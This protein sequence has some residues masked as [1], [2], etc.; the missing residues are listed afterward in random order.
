MG[1]N[2]T[3]PVN[4]QTANLPVVVWLYGEAFIFGSKDAGFSDQL[5]LYN[6]SG[7]LSQG[8]DFIFITGNYRLGAFGWLDGPVVAQN[9]APNA[10]LWD[11]RLLLD[12]VTKHISTFGGTRTISGSGAS[13]LEL[14]PSS[15][16]SHRL[17]RPHLSVRHS[18]KAQRI[19]GSGTRHQKV[20]QRRFSTGS[21]T[22]ATVATVAIL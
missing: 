10:G 9:C 13:L 14:V 6:A 16:I 12:F 7:L 11:Q 20:T 19:S 22:R 15:T 18:C 3:E 5:P 2:V 8:K 1:A 4:K 17:L 21:S